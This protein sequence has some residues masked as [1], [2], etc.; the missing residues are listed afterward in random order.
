MTSSRGAIRMLRHFAKPWEVK[1]PLPVDPWRGAKKIK[2]RK[3]EKKEVSPNLVRGL[4]EGEVVGEENGLIK[5]CKCGGK[6]NTLGR[7]LDQSFKTWQ[8][9]R[10]TRSL[11]PKKWRGPGGR[12]GGGN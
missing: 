11:E 2:K 6:K 7:G 3:E 1:K 8:I 9:N 5:P 12:V 10:N 4:G